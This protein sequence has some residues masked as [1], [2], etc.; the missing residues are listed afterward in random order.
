MGLAIAEL[1]QTL[2]PIAS[3]AAQLAGNAGVQAGFTALLDALLGGGKAADTGVS[4][5]CAGMDIAAPAE[6]LDTEDALA[7]ALAAL[8]AGLSLPAAVAAEPAATQGAA[9]TDGFATAGT[10]GARPTVNQ[11]A[12]L[13]ALLA[14]PAPITEEAWASGRARNAL[15][16]VPRSARG[17]QAFNLA[18]VQGHQDQP[19]TGALPAAA[20]P[21]GLDGEP[22]TQAPPGLARA[23][24]EHAA[25]VVRTVGNAAP[26]TEADD[27]QLAPAPVVASADPLPEAEAPAPQPVANTVRVGAD[28]P[29]VEDAASME[30]ARPPVAEM[31]EAVRQVGRAVVERLEQGGGGAR[32]HLDPPELGRVVIDVR[33]EGASVHV[34][35]DAEQP[36]TARLLQEHSVDL[37][38]LFRD[39][40]LQL[41]VQVG[42]HGQ[43]QQGEN[44]QAWAPGPQHRTGDVTFASIFRGEPAQ[45]AVVHRLRAAYNP[46]GHHIYRI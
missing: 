4:P 27:A 2:F 30:T 38:R 19:E 34:H 31:P 23:Q 32:I 8:S 20:P 36:E 3:G 11:L 40:G 24:D 39:Q 6:E 12:A 16:D 7:S 22:P 33:S 42:H 37:E 41:N 15:Q 14:G 28:A 5:D 25:S 35:V 45:P 10:G 1:S 26:A 13:N 21:P 29:Q 44:G 43:Q 17:E 18:E 9:P 46:D